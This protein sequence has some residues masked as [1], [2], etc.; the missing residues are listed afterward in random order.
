MRSKARSWPVSVL[1]ARRTAP[2]S[3]LLG[4][5]CA[6][7][8]IAIAVSLLAFGAG[9]SVANAQTTIEVEKITCA[10]FVT[11]QVADPNQIGIWISGYFHGRHGDKILRVQDLRKKIDALKTACYLT[12]NSERPVMEVSE[13]LPSSK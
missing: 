6:P 9:G 7:S 11:F 13:G 10:Q 8:P 2:S 3:G 12:A 5:W 1:V 4:T